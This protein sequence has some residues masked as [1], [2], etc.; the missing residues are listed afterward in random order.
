MFEVL[1]VGCGTNP[2]GDVNIDLHIGVSEHR[3]SK[4][5]IPKDIPNFLRCSATHLPFKTN[6]FNTVFS[7]Y[8]LEHVGSKPQESN[9]APYITL[10]EMIRVSKRIIEIYVPH[11][12]S[13]ANSEKKFWKRE[14]NAFFNLRWFARVIPKIEKELNI[15]LSMNPQLTFKPLLVYF[16]QMPDTIHIILRKMKGR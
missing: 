6:S 3:D 2:M 5:L 12:F 15:R 4:P 16:L 9:P 14:H 7:K 1:D 8:C 10:R 13:R 11:R